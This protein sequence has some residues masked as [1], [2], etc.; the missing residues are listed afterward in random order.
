MADIAAGDVTYVISKKSIGESGNRQ[1]AMSIAFGDGALT[2]PSGGIPLT[3]AKMGCPNQIIDFNLK[4]DGSASA[5]I[6][7]YDSVNNKIRI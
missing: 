7:K 2:Y 3:A 4:N 6:Y 1:F 5:L